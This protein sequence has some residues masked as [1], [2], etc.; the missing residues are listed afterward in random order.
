MEQNQAELDGEKDVSIVALQ[1][2]TLK[3]DESSSQD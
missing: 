2:P 1:N 3:M